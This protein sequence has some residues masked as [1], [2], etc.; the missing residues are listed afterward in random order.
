MRIGIFGGSF[1]PIHTGHA[2]VANELSQ[3]GL[4]DEVWLMPARINPF[5][6][7]GPRPAVPEER[8]SMCRLVA[9]ECARVRVSDLE[10]KLPEP[11]YT[12]VTLCEL[13]RQWPQHQFRVIIGSD[14]WEKFS[15]WCESEKIIREFGVTIYIRPDYPLNGN[16]PENVEVADGLPQALI[17]STWL[18]E[19]ITA[20]RNVNY[21]IPQK[22][23]D[24]IREHNLYKKW[25]R[26]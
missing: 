19:S 25:N 1:D 8:V 24:Y 23:I 11:S 6:A 4:F 7:Q 5:K 17:S 21:L 3:C 12:Y 9:E 18:R 2:I 26:T 20:G 10:L 15:K 22:V 13:R 16:L 14:N